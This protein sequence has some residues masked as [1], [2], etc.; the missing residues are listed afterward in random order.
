MSYA[1]D[2]SGLSSAN[3]ITDE[4]AYISS[5]RE[6]KEPALVIPRLAP[7]FGWNLEIYTA[8]DKK[9]QLLVN[10]EDY[11]LLNPFVPFIETQGKEFFYGI[12]FKNHEVTK[13]L[14][15]HYNAL[16][17]TFGVDELGVFEDLL[18]MMTELIH[19]HWDQI[20]GK[21]ATYPPRFHTHKE[22]EVPMPALVSKV[23]SLV[24]KVGA[25]NGIP[26]DTT[27]PGVQ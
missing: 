16:G 18:G 20:E 7:F 19:Y 1:L 24:T 23:M 17:G 8:K 27:L 4:Y 15:L 9:G 5:G 11:I 10:G 14:W 2:V 22:S 21:P 12:W 3:R 13:D 6:L 26:V 25:V